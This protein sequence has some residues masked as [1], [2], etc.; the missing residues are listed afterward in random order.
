VS[1]NSADN[2]LVPGQ[3]LAARRGGPSVVAGI[4]Y[5]HLVAIN[6]AI[7]ALPIWGSAATA[8]TLEHRIVIVH[9]QRQLGFDLGVKTPDSE[10]LMEVKVNPSRDD[11]RSFVAN[12]RDALGEVP[13]HVRF[14]LVV[15]AETAPVQEL[16]ELIFIAAES[17]SDVDFAGRVPQRSGTEGLIAVAGAQPAATFARMEVVLRPPEAEQTYTQTLARHLSRDPSKAGQMVERIRTRVVD[18]SKGRRRLDVEALRDELTTLGLL[19]PVE[20]ELGDDIKADALFRA[21]GRCCICG[22]RG[23]DVGVHL[24]NRVATDHDPDNLVVL[25]RAC[26]AESEHNFAVGPAR[27]IDRLTM[28]RRRWD[29]EVTRQRRSQASAVNGEPA[30]S[31]LALVRAHLIADYIWEGDHRGEFTRLGGRL[32]DRFY[33][34]NRGERITARPAYYHTYWG[35]QGARAVLP[36]KF[37]QYANVTTDS[38]RER[39]TRGGWITVDLEDYSA[40]PSIGFRRVETIRHT[41]RAAAILLTVGHHEQILHEV[42]WR[43]LVAADTEMGPDGAWPEFRG[44]EGEPSLYSSTYVLHLLGGALADDTLRRTIPEA[45]DFVV[46]ATD[47]FGRTWEYLWQRWHAGR[48]AMGGLPWEVNAAAMLADFGPYLPEQHAREIFDDLRATADP[49]GSLIN[50]DAGREWGA[51]DPILA[52]RIAFALTRVASDWSGDSRVCNLVQRVID[53]DWHAATLHT[54]DAAFLALLIASDGSTSTA[55]SRE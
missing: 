25:C 32:E 21:D 7:R 38:I 10:L 46:R 37:P 27:E 51:P 29:L 33:Q 19:K 18:A 44:V 3:P 34:S 55:T 8:V 49:S 48:W 24:I 30:S 4:E 1:Q 31:L 13:D 14:T 28:A 35:L 5:Q 16:G 26:A 17:E 52:L 12:V 20:S 50:S 36:D 42:I 11:A 41:A 23:H 40:P 53:A 6:E 2:K 15:G 45:D 43:V 54:M 9:R 47:V 22:R 39:L